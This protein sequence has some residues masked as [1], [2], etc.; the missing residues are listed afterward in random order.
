MLLYLILRKDKRF[1]DKFVEVR[2]LNEVFDIVKQESPGWEIDYVI[3]VKDN[4]V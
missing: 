3:K 2:T 1:K 4:E